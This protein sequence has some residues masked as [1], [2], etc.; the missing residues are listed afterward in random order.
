[1]VQEELRVQYLV[2]KPN[3]RRLVSWQLGLVSW[4]PFPQW[5]TSS[6][7]TSPSNSTTP[8]AK[9]IQTTTRYESECIP[10]NT[11]PFHSSGLVY[12]GRIFFPFLGRALFR[13]KKKFSALGKAMLEKHGINFTI[14]FTSL[15]KSSF[16]FSVS[17]LF[18]SLLSFFLITS[19]FPSLLIH[20]LLLFLFSVL[21]ASCQIKGPANTSQ[22][23]YNWIIVSPSSNN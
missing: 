19:P 3:R 12:S 5:H 20:S 2:P 18:F 11:H 22:M 21:D 10:Y 1:M 4:S 8:L 16:F 17:P 6:N 7:K 15:K 23:L 13:K 9:H 14:H